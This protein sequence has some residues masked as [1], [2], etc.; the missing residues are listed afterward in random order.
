MQEE[1]A[2][3][4]RLAIFVF[5]ADRMKTYGV[6]WR[7]LLPGKD[8][9][10]SFFRV[11]GLSSPEVARLGLQAG[12]NRADQQLQGWAEIRAVEVRKQPP[13][14]LNPAEPPPRHG[15]VVGWPTASQD[16]NKLALALAAKIKS[17][18]W[19]G[20]TALEVLS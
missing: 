17:F 19:D 9:E 6:H 16:K 2:D 11:N 20:Y 5:D 1:I 7:A 4:E 3:A 12:E 15:V 18:R 10:R 13:L 14:V 8:G